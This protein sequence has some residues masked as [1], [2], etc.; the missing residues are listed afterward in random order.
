MTFKLTTV[1]TYGLKWKPKQSSSQQ[2]IDAVKNY[3]K[4]LA[5]HEG[6]HVQDLK[7]IVK[8]A[9]DKWIDRPYYGCGISDQQ[10]MN[11][12]KRQIKQ[13]GQKIVNDMKNDYET[14]YYPKVEEDYKINLDCSACSG[15]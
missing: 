11:D 1:V 14:N 12:I 8:K 7:D 13:D 10:A 3:E 4:E 2:C 9:N 5:I 15:T 6:K